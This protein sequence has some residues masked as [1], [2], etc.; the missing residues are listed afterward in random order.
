MLPLAR[1]CLARLPLATARF[2]RLP[3]WFHGAP[4]VLTRD[5]SGDVIQRRALAGEEFRQKIWAS[6][7]KNEAAMV[8]CGF[9]AFSH[10]KC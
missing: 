2:P 1:L 5:H 4:S 6:F 3:F 10:I 9:A 8:K 7:T